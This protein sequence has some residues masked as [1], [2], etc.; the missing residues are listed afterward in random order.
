MT[1]KDNAVPK[2]S[3]W[4]MTKELEKKV[5][6]LPLNK[7]RHLTSVGYIAT[8]AYKLPADNKWHDMMLNDINKYQAERNKNKRSNYEKQNLPK[9][10]AEL[11][12][13]AREYKISIKRIYKKENPTLSELYKVQKWV[14]LRLITE[15]PL[16]NDLPTV[17]IHEKTGNYLDKSG[18]TGLK[19]VMQDFKASDKVG[20]REIK[21]SRS[22]A[23]V[24]KNFIVYRKKAGID[25]DFLL[26]SQNGQR[27]TKGGYSQMLIKTTNELLGKRV[28]SRMIR[29]LAATEH[30]DVIDKVDNLTNKLLHTSKQTRQYIRRGE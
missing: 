5:K 20:T 11:K 12:R 16:R 21:L 18:K 9:N 1:G 4:M 8:K 6:N 7:R 24:L 23:T 26:S 29:V 14:V 30:K 3:G 27:M 28:G 25:H 17:N 13:A 22:V 2:T 15:L 19:L 10:V